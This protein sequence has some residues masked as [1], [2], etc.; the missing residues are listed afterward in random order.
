MH[1]FPLQFKHNAGGICRWSVMSCGYRSGWQDNYLFTQFISKAAPPD[2]THTVRVIVDILY[3]LSSCRARYNCNPKFQLLK[4]ETD[5]PQPR[6]V[7]TDHTNYQSIRVRTGSSAVTQRLVENIDIPANIEGIYLAVRDNTSCIQVAQMQVY[8]YQCPRKQ[9]GLV[10]F[11]DTAAPV[12]GNM[13]ITAQCMPDSYPVTDMDILCY[14]TGYW[15]GSGRCRCYP[16]YYR[17]R[18]VEGDYCVRKQS[19]VTGIVVYA[20]C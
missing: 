10:V 17:H 16:G 2:T 20:N 9:E 1:C 15:S 11:P 13:T 7:F 5:G 4:F 12:N 14:D 19:Y 8:R 3:T 6:E 18:G